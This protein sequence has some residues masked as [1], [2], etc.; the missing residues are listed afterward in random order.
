M[1]FKRLD[2]EDISISAESVVAPLWSTDTKYLTTFHTASGQVASNTGNYFY[3]VYENLPSNVNVP[4]NVQFAIAYGHKE[5]KG[6]APYTAANQIVPGKSPTTTIYG[7][8][9]NLIFGDEETGFIFGT[10]ESNDIYVIS[11]DRARYREKLLPGSFNLRLQ[12]GSQILNLTDNSKDLTTVSYV[13]AGRVYD[14]VEGTDGA[15]TAGTGY[16]PSNGSYGKFLPDVGIIVL[17]GKALQDGGFGLTHTEDIDGSE[18]G[19]NLNHFYNAI[20]LGASSSLQSEETI[21]SNY[22]FVRV[23][24]SEFNY[25]TNPSNITSSGDLRHNIM[26]NTPQAYI[27]TVGMYNDNNDLLGVAKLSRPLLKDFTK[28]ALI[29]IKLDY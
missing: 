15:A 27:T 28:E 25:T 3:E 22:V 16:S 4:S 5:G 11:I 13:D 19:T 23:R 26:I 1:S 8:Y 6:A 24:N 18:A 9:R 20:K 2:P 14:V 29:R 17:N 12:E 21:S 7:Q 10:Q